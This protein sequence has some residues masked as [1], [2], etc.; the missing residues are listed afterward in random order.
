MS[1]PFFFNATLASAFSA[2]GLLIVDSAIKGALL[3][4]IAGVVAWALRRDSAATRHWVWLVAIVSLLLM[5]GISAVLPQWRVLPAWMTMDAVGSQPASAP[6]RITSPNI[7]LPRA[8]AVEHAEKSQLPLDVPSELIGANPE[9]EVSQNKSVTSPPAT[10]LTTSVVATGSWWN[11]QMASSFCWAIGFVV[12]FIRLA[13]AR[14]LLW[15]TERSATVACDVSTTGLQDHAEVVAAFREAA[16]QLGIKQPVTLLIHAEKSIPVVWGILRPRLLLP[17]I[18]GQWSDE[19]LRSV[20]LHEL[21]HIKRRDALSQLLAQA[22]C[23]LHWF[24]PLVWLAVWRLHVERERACDDLVLASGV[25]ASAYAEH[26]LNVA[27]RLTSSP[28]T[29]ACGLAMAR[30]SSL[31]GRIT[32][33]LNAKQ[34]RRKL[35]TVLLVSSMV[36]TIAFVIPIAMMSAASEPVALTSNNDQIDE[37][38]AGEKPADGTGLP[39]GIEQHL[40]WSQPVNGLRAAMMIRAGEAQGELGKERKI[41]LVLQNVSDQSIRYCDSEIHETKVPA[42]D[43]EGRKLYLRD[44]GEIM[45][46]IQHALS[47]QTDIV[48]QPRQV[49]SIDMFDSEQEKAQG[50]KTGDMMAEGI[51]KDPSQELFAV[52]KIVHAPAGAWTGKLT[53]PNTRGAFA[54][55]GSMPS[56]QPGQAL[57]RYSIDHARLSGEI[58][59]GIISRLRD[60][61]QEFI[62]LNSGDQSGDPYAKKMQL[63]LP[64][65]E[66][67]GDWKQ[68]EVVSLFD[69]I[70]AVTT[71]PLQRTLD[72][73]RENSLQRGQALPT[74]LANANWGE[75]L[76]GGLRMAWVLEPREKAIPIGSSLKSRVVLHNSGKEPVI[77]VTR[78]F[79]QPQHSAGSA[80]GAAMRLDATFWTTIGRPEPYR[81]HPGECCELYAPGIGIGARNNNLEDWANVRAGTWILADSGA[82]VVFQPGAVKL[83]GNHTEQ[84]DPDWWLKFITE[85]IQRETPLPVDAKERE[86]ILFRVVSDL[87]G[88]SPG[89]EEAAAFLSDNTPEAVN[90]LAKLLSTRTWHKSVTGAIKSGELRFRVLPADPNA[91][92]RPRVTMNPGRFNLSE[93]V[94]LVVT[95]KPAGERIVNEANIVWSPS[96]KDD[97]QTNV[98][99]PGDYDTWAAGW[100]PRTT[101]LWVSQNGLLRSYDFTDNAAIK[102]TRYEGEQMAAAPVPADVRDALGSALKNA[103]PQEKP[104]PRPPAALAPDKQSNKVLPAV[105]PKDELSRVIMEQWRKVARSDGR[106]PGAT[107]SALE[108]P[109]KEYS[110]NFA[111][112]ATVL[113]RFDATRDWTEAEAAALLNAV[114]EI[115]SQPINKLINAYRFSKPA[116]MRL[117][118]PLP[119]DL[120]N[121]SW[122]KPVE[123]GLRSA[124]LVERQA[125]EIAFGAKV[126]LRVLVHNAGTAPVAFL[127]PRHAVPDGV[128]VGNAR[129][130][131]A[132][133]TQLLSLERVRLNPGDYVEA[134][135]FEIAIDEHY[136]EKKSESRAVIEAQAGI[137]FQ[138]SF[139]VDLTERFLR[140]ADGLQ[141]PDAILKRDIVNRVAEEAPLPTSVA[142][143]ELLLR[144]VT[145]DMFG[146]PPTAKEIAEFAA[147]NSKDSLKNLTSRLQVRQTSALFVGAIPSGEVILRVSPVE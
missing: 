57:F 102:E 52:L 110:T 106:I 131:V 142:D 138:V 45:F 60:L 20:L 118:K 29:Q 89:T 41:F 42:A 132:P 85:R 75:A 129:I 58:P 66:K 36:I 64:R 24:N 26:L 100:S 137:E 91:A 46:A 81:L 116:N 44:N 62:R 55:E 48:L 63:L 120:A 16:D 13:I 104:A 141:D 101:I 114:A 97:V 15:R 105:E 6:M 123:H 59:G 54:A 76:P 19:Q 112:L 128:R 119:A 28:W 84:I 12:L 9:N 18:A 5:P 21:A 117:G 53:A 22:A 113:T 69:E 38:T 56:S 107:V 126:K 25:R 95:R 10:W 94:R 82:E 23:A 14:A 121:V 8:R 139:L 93:Q 92:T 32:A 50:R 35:T 30:S 11:W 70:A 133:W 61:V 130:H 146:E 86:V 17:A 127:F 40:D 136:D 2:P 99:L 72:A 39:A 111:K 90:N 51:V 27:T 145:L 103:V 78:S 135:R 3:L 143:R 108:A 74:S 98:P 67:K 125:K 34:N 147:D 80:S 4:S 73:I 122:G 96:G 37:K 47:S 140:Q 77:F 115:E 33:V 88:T 7:E 109:V 68:A 49:H 65:F 87:F 83:T 43:V 144:H 79:Q 31:H 134:E 124:C 1:Q 71:I